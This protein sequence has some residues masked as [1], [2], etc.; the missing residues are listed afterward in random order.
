MAGARRFYPN[1]AGGFMIFGLAALVYA[2]TTSDRIPIVVAAL[3][4]IGIILSVVVSWY[5]KR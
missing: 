3:T 5:Q 1:V 4:G 2:A